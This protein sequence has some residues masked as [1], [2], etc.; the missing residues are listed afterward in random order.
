MLILDTEGS[1]RAF[2][3]GNRI[4]GHAGWQL[5]EPPTDAFVR[6]FWLTQGRGMMDVHVVESIPLD[7]TLASAT[8]PFQFTLPPGPY[9]FTGSLISLYWAIELA[10]NKGEDLTRIDLTVTPWRG[11]LALRQLPEE[12]R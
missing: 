3:P 5:Q 7:V 11:P 8:H 1:A 6:L 4:R 12:K 9:G 10:L 2:A